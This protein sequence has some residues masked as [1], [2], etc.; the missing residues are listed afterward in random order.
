MPLLSAFKGE[1]TLEDFNVRV[2]FDK[3]EDQNLHLAS[4][5]ARHEADLR[6][7]YNRIAMQ[8]ED[9]KKML[10]EFD[11][12]KLE[13]WTERQRSAAEGVT[14]TAAAGSDGTTFVHTDVRLGGATRVFKFTGALGFLF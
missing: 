4:Q 10:G 13:E 14:G 7:F 3:L 6:G 2:L 1:E 8:N 12:T 5:L 9:L 11:V